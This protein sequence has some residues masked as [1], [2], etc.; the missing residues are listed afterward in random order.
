MRCCCCAGATEAMPRKDVR[1][2]G[3]ILAHVSSDCI[4][5][6]RGEY[7]EIVLPSRAEG[8]GKRISMIRTTPSVIYLPV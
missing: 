7:H 5:D 1:R 8:L 2:I 4:S 6:Y 3:V